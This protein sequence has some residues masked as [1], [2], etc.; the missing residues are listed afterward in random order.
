M[1][2]LSNTKLLLVFTLFMNFTAQAQELFFS[3]GVNLTTYDFKGTDNLP[4]EL[5]SK[6]GQF[7]EMGY[8]IKMMDDR[9][10]YGLALAINNFN[11]TGGD[12]ANNYEWETTYLGIN[13]SLEYVLIQNNR[14]SY[15][16][17]SGGFQLQIMHIVSGE[18]KI[19]GVLFD[20][21]KEDEFKGLWVQPGFL[22]TTKYYAS[23][24]WQFSLGYNYSLG[25]NTSNSTEEKLKFKNHQIRFGIHFNLN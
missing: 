9:L 14:S 13:N 15:F 25:L 22:L 16:E 20:L 3:T 23:D 1:K 5:K 7:Y 17:L 21:T 19:N 24:D 8:R 11:A 18:Q 6:T 4:L 10:N 2:L 12:I